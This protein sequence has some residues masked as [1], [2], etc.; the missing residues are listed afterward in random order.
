MNWKE[1]NGHILAKHAKQ[2]AE[3]VNAILLVMVAKFVILATL[4][5]VSQPIHTMKQPTSHW[6]FN[7]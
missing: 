4:D 6:S 7:Q 3:D 2:L 1:Y 5:I